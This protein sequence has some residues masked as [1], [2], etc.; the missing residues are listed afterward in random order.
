MR[1]DKCISAHVTHDR[2]T[3]SYARSDA[4]GKDT[5]YF[6]NKEDSE[7]YT[8]TAE[9]SDSPVNPQEEAYNPETGEIN[10]DCPW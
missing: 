10:W 4:D 2:L 6:V 9:Q 8:G 3:M 7:K 5:L 1:I